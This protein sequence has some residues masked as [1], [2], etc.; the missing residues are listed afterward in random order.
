MTSLTPVWRLIIPQLAFIVCAAV[1]LP[2]VVVDVPV[3]A[4]QTNWR[5]SRGQGSCVWASLVTL[6]RWQNRPVTAAWIRQNCGDGASPS[7]VEPLFERLGIRYATT[8]GKKDVNF[9]NWSIRTHRGCAVGVNNYAHMVCLVA[10]NDNY[11]GILDNNSVGQ[12]IWIPREQFLA[13]WFKS[14]SWAVTPV[15]T[16]SAP[17]PSEAKRVQPLLTCNTHQ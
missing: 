14:H 17:A 12:V 9:L 1:T 4:R 3:P 13:D 7:D 15:Y 10:L 8:Y 16:P 11:A 5:G 2:S 6:F